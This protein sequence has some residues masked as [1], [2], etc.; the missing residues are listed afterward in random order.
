MA[1]A[2]SFWEVV[3]AKLKHGVKYMLT[4]GLYKYE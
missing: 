2:E 4:K 1:K 3:L